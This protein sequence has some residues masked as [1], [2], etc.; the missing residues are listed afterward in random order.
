M[1]KRFWLFLLTVCMVWTAMPFGA[2][3]V[4]YPNNP[5]TLPIG[6]QAYA[7]DGWYRFAPTT[8]GQSR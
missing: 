4:D 7:A 5:V 3:A 1:K 2:F 6:G 8:D